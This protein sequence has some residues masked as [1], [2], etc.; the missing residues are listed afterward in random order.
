MGCPRA[1][2]GSGLIELLAAW[3]AFLFCPESYVDVCVSQQFQDST[4]WR[5]SM[6]GSWFGGESFSKEESLDS[7]QDA[8]PCESYVKIPCCLS[9][10]QQNFDH[11]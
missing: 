5:C 2:G 6:M 11:I 7:D 4:S 8:E 3:K 1:T 10:H 9:V